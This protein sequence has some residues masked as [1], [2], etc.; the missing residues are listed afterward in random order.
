LLAT[1][2]SGVAACL[3][4]G[5]V[6]NRVDTPLL[7][8][9][10]AYWPIA[11]VFTAFAIA[12]IANAINII[13]GFNGLSTGTVMIILSA[14]WS[15][16]QIEGDVTLA[17]NCLLF[18]AAIFGFWL[19]NFP[20]GKIFLGDGG[21]YF[22]GFALAWLAILLMMR[23]PTV[24][25]WTVLLASAYPVVEVLYS[26][27]RRK[28]LKQPTGSPD[29]LHLHSVIKTQIILPHLTMW[30]PQL[31]NAAVSPLI[32]LLASLPAFLA[33]FFVGASLWIVTGLFVAFVCTYHCIYQYVIEYKPIIA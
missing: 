1:M 5:V 16:A 31:R 20:F 13:D 23:N 7:D 17:A 10:L 2:C 24:S 28:R 19:V 3:I 30:P 14:L 15:I 27:W 4:T 9:L 22:V 29:S 21:A 12:G 33:V 6:L 18:G 8:D 11:L 26:M 25:P 32:W